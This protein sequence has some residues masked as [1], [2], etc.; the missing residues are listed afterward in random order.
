MPERLS[1][2]YR[3]RL[4]RI[5]RWSVPALALATV[6]GI[7]IGALLWKPAQS[8]LAPE[9]ALTA[10]NLLASAYS[11]LGEERGL[12]FVALKRGASF[13]AKTREMLTARRARANAALDQ[14]SDQINARILDIDPD[15]LFVRTFAEHRTAVEKLR[16][17]TDAWSPWNDSKEDTHLPR[18]WFNSM[19]R[20][21]ASMS[22][23]HTVLHMGVKRTELGAN[24]SAA[25]QMQYLTL[26]MNDYAGRERAII[27]GA[28]AEN[29]PLSNN[30]RDELRT[31]T[32]RVA[33]IRESIKGLASS[34]HIPPQVKNRIERFD[35]AYFGELAE[36]RAAL[37][38]AN[39]SGK[40]YPM[41]AQQW[42]NKSSRAIDTIVEISKSPVSVPTS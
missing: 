4:E 33:T 29:E 18:I 13:D 9:Q 1:V 28:I 35:R 23:L 15:D 6:A 39:E 32:D 20:L 26:L 34:E 8:A 10:L 24:R 7:G 37:L 41:S 11:D 36:T 17:E 12:A 40:P 21:L 16:K 42:F 14:I 31:F 19:N 22:S 2:I 5:G 30:E 25:L 38:S 3:R 27:S